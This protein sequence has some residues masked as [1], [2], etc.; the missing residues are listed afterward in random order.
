MD[1]DRRENCRRAEG[2]L[3]DE[4]EQGRSTEVR[5]ITSNFRFLRRRRSRKQYRET[6]LTVRYRW[7]RF[8]KFI[9]Y[10]TIVD[11]KRIR[12]PLMERKV[13]FFRQLYVLYETRGA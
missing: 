11:I 8:R 9:N 6:V 5:R 4:P 7:S 3:E 10:E 13:F 12:R 2:N 1:G